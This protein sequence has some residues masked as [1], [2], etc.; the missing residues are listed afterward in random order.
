MIG[1]STEPH[2]HDILP[3]SNVGM[4]WVRVQGFDDAA[5]DFKQRHR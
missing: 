4:A 5:E 2:V 3:W 1:S